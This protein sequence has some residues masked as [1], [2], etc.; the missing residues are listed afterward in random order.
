M[1][2]CKWRIT[3]G[4]TTILVK[5]EEESEADCQAMENKFENQNRR[6]PPDAQCAPQK[7]RRKKEKK[8]A[9]LLKLMIVWRNRTDTITLYVLAI[10]SAGLTLLCALA[11]FERTDLLCIITV[12]FFILCLV[13][14]FMMRRRYGAHLESSIRRRFFSR[15]V[16]DEAADLELIKGLDES[17]FRK[18]DS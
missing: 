3:E 13:Q 6:E 15:D 2:N 18:K 14:T 8:D 9:R 7:N 1:Q 11:G 4:W 17:V 16:D 10:I 5:P 12:V